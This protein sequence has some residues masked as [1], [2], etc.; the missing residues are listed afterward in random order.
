MD[1]DSNISPRNDRCLSI[2]DK[3]LTDRLQVG[4]SPILITDTHHLLIIS[5]I[6]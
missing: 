6:A 3:Y 2:G 1:T 5:G 4:Y